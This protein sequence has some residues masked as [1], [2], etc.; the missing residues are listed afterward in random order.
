[1]LTCGE[2]HKNFPKNMLKW[3][4]FLRS[5]NMDEHK[6]YIVYFIIIILLVYQEKVSDVYEFFSTTLIAKI[7]EDKVSMK[8]LSD[9]FSKI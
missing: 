1:M 7:S 3:N 9:K 8:K 6:A 4:L 5:S 2:K